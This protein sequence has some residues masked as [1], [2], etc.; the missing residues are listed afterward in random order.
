LDV[1]REIAALVTAVALGAGDGQGVEQLGDDARGRVELGHGR[2]PAAA[3]AAVLLGDP[4]AHAAAAEG[5]STVGLHDG[6][7]QRFVAHHTLE[8]LVHLVQ[9]LVLHFIALPTINKN[10]NK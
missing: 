4:R 5:H 6:V 1:T 7:H 8:G 10:E 3:R 9:I 2:S